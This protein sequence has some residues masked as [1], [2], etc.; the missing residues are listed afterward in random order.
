MYAMLLPFCIMLR[1]SSDQLRQQLEREYE[2]S[3]DHAGL[4]ELDRTLLSVVV[5]QTAQLPPHERWARFIANNGRSLHTIGHRPPWM[6]LILQ[7]AGH[8][9]SSGVHGDSVNDNIAAGL[10]TTLPQTHQ[11]AH[12]FEVESEPQQ[13]ESSSPPQNV[14]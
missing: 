6:D 7:F 2:L 14:K 11:F 5:A 10:S 12:I 1:V 4:E 9:S 8:Q 3:M 13:R